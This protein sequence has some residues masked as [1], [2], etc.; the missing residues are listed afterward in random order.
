[1]AAIDM[2]NNPSEGDT[3]LAGNGI[4]YVWDGEK[5]IVRTEASTGVNLWAR[6]PS[7]ETLQSIYNG[8]SVIITGDD[9]STQVTL[10]PE[11]ITGT[12]NI[13]GLPALP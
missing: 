2:P 13:D 6:D 8:D 10:A 5:W 4:N 7:N 9:G 3:Y 11:G 12:Y 1:M